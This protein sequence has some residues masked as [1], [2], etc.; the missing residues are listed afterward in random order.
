MPDYNMDELIKRINE[1][2]HKNKT[3]GLNAAELE[4]RAELRK[5]YIQEFRKGMKQNIMDN[6]YIMDKDGNKVKVEPKNKK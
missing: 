5:L 4:E 2:A 6:L 3:V 1:L